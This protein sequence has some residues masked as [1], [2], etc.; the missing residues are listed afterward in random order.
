MVA[1]A[2]IDGAFDGLI[3]T[4]FCAATSS[5]GGTRTLSTKSSASQPRTMGIDRRRIHWAM[6]DGCR[7]VCRATHAPASQARLPHSV[8]MIRSQSVAHADFT[9]Q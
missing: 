5:N 9:K 8:P 6:N 1:I 3:D 2:C 4:W 7:R